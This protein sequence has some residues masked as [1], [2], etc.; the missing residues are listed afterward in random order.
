MLMSAEFNMNNKKLG[1][2][3]MITAEANNTLPREQYGCRT[4]HKSIIALLNKKLALDVIRQKKLMGAICFNDAKSCFDR[5][6]HNIA[7][8][9]M[10]RQGACPTATRQMFSVLRNAKHHIKSAYG[11]SE[12]IY[13]PNLHPPP[14]G[15]GQGN[16]AGPSGWDAVSA[17]IINAMRAQNFGFHYISPIS[18]QLIDFVG[19]AFVDDTDLIHTPR[20]TLQTTDQ[21]LND[22]EEAILTWEGLLR[23][24]G[25]AIVPAKS[26]WYFLDQK[27]KKIDGDT[28]RKQ[29]NPDTYICKQTVLKKF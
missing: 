15:I 1:R 21:F 25:G 19:F 10:I 29:N 13:G 28:S 8:M 18:K 3:M 22:F 5:I 7:T 12:E 24:T 23:A 16:G 9:S 2:E 20:A 4:Y 17:P 14:Q 6:V 27:W 11:R 26:C